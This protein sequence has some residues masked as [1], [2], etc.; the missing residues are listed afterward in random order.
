MEVKI[1]GLE[2]GSEGDRKKVEMLEPHT[3]RLTSV[4]E[5]PFSFEGIMMQTALIRQG[6]DWAQEQDKR[7]VMEFIGE[8][9][10]SERP[11]GFFGE[12]AGDEKLEI[13]DSWRRSVQYRV[14]EALGVRHSHMSAGLYAFQPPVVAFVLN[15]S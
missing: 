7:T 1:E 15:L 12:P 5:T 13:R 9:S 2:R 11:G 10:D 8:G 3:I 4:P 6:K 14:G